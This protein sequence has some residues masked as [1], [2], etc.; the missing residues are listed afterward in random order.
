MNVLVSNN[1]LAMASSNVLAR[2]MHADGV[3]SKLLRCVRYSI[4]AFYFRFYSSQY[5]ITNGFSGNTNNLMQNVT[6]MYLEHP[7]NLMTSNHKW[8]HLS[9]WLK[10]MLL[11]LY[12]HLKTL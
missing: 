9:N 8:K 5:K 2:S 7:D 10:L 3:S 6:I 12:E 11:Y 1:I 4:V